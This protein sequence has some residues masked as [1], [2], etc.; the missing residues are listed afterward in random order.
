MSILA[1]TA[2]LYQAV[3]I[4]V[5]APAQAAWKVGQDA[6]PVRSWSAASQQLAK[7]LLT[8][9]TIAGL[10]AGKT[11]W[12]PTYGRNL[13]SQQPVLACADLLQYSK[14]LCQVKGTSRSQVCLDLHVNPALP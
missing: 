14:Y 10:Q 1:G 7:L 6:G 8:A 3:N 2:A 4:Y 9:T 5:L 13:C 12:L 11:G